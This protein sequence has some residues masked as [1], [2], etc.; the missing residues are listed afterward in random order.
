MSN[1]PSMPQ[2]GIVTSLNKD[3]GQAKAFLPLFKIETG[4][5]P[6]ATNLLYETQVGMQQIQIASPAATDVQATGGTVAAPPMCPGTFSTWGAAALGASQAA[7]PSGSVDRVD[8]GTLQVG[9]EVLVVF[10]NGDIN[11]GRIIARF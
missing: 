5:I 8:Y 9:D 2:A 11:Q 3:A 7:A 10:L 1:N 6:V 4:W